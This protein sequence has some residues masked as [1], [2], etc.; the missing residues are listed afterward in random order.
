MSVEL[1]YKTADEREQEEAAAKI[2]AIKRG[3]ADRAKAELMKQLAAS[4]VWAAVKAD[5][6]AKLSAALA[7]S[8]DGVGL[9]D[10]ELGT[11]L[12][13]AIAEAKFESAKVLITYDAALGMP[14]KE[15]A[16]WQQI[17]KDMLPIPEGEEGEEKDVQSEEYQAELAAS[18]L[19]D[20]DAAEAG[21]LIKR[22]VKIGLYEGGR[23]AV[24]EPDMAF[25][26]M[27]GDKSGYGVMLSATGDVY[28]GMYGAGGLREGVGALR[29]KEGTVYAGQWA[30]GKRH[31][32]GSMTY[33]DGGKYMGAWAYG[34]RHGKGDFSYAN[35][36]SYSG[37]WHA[38]NKH[39]EGKYTATSAGSVYLGTWKHGALMASK[40]EFTTAD[41]AAF[42]GTFEQKTGR[43]T[44]PG[45]FAYGNGVSLSGSYLAPPIDEEAGEDPPVVLPSVWTGDACGALAPTSD[46]TF[47]A[48]LM[49]V[50]PTYNVVISGAP[51]SGKGTQCEKLVAK[52]GLVHL[53]TG[54]ILRAAAE[55]PENEVGQI[56]KEKME[57]GE[58]VPDE[59]I[60]QLLVQKL[61]TDEVRDKGFLLD[62]YPRTQV[63]AGEMEKYFILPNK[64]IIIDVP[65]EVLVDR[66][67]GRRLDPETGTIYHMVTKP[68]YKL[69]EEGN[70]VDEVITDEEGNSTPTGKKAMDEEVLARLTQRDD[71]TEEAL[72]VRLAT[73]AENK[74][75]ISAAFASI[76]LTVDG[77]RDPDEVFADIDAFIS[78]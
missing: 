17:Q 67:T 65:E 13:Y 51:A 6:V 15:L 21:Y 20:M 58:L 28:A 3:Q 18:L 2:Q 47:R 43:P 55:D 16:V 41:K 8:S 14:A 50:P 5:D 38:G 66:V 64:V 72:K 23:V 54:D 56:A 53:S 70:T 46:A 48:E 1:K 24:A 74:A 4:P 32:P 27:V 75:A 36:D 34:K 78:K 35:G 63:Q 57:A 25:D 71:D 77:N 52:Y 69:D 29:T 30:G 9:A 39:G 12:A 19:A 61:D 45:A 44:G 37:L 60:T 59:L 40:V 42:Y 73:F 7:E 10:P 33:K 62:G 49:K 26:T 68:P 31:G 76:A 11:P 22:I